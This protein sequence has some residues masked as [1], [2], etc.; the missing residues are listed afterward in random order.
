MVLPPLEPKYK[1]VLD[2]LGLNAAVPLEPVIVTRPLAGCRDKISEASPIVEIVLVYS[3][4]VMFAL[5]RT[6]SRFCGVV[7]LMPI[8]SVFELTNKVF[9]S[10][11]RFFLKSVFPNTKRSSLTVRFCLVTFKLVML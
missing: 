10:T 5:P 2:E 6:F 11:V 4:P 8:L 7:V 9:V 3:V 1:A